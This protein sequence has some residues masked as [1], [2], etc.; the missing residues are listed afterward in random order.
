MTDYS[1]G[2]GK[3]ANGALVLASYTHKTK[4]DYY[5]LAY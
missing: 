3:C 4:V 1:V 2:S 5:T